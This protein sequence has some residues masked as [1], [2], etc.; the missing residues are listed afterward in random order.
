M[1]YFRVKGFIE[2]PSR[3]TQGEARKERDGKARF[4]LVPALVI[5]RRSSV[6]VDYL[7]TQLLDQ[8]LRGDFILRTSIFQIT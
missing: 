3:S 2:N 1:Y 6:H 7:A 8:G 5:V 4:R